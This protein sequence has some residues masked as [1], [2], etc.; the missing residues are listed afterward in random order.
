VPGPFEQPPIVILPAALYF[1]AVLT[2]VRLRRTFDAGAERKPGHQLAK[3]DE[4]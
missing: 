3:G 1:F 4:T 2:I